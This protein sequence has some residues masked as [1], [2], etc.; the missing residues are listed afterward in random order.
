MH[1]VLNIL[2]SFAAIH[3]ARLNVEELYISFK[4]ASEPP[5]ALRFKIMG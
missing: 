3:A 1:N 2:A 4:S 5:S